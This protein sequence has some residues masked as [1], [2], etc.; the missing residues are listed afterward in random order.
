LNKRKQLIT[1]QPQGDRVFLQ[2]LSAVVESSHI[3]TWA[4]ILTGWKC[5]FDLLSVSHVKI[6]S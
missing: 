4:Q 6:E 2:D 3:R 1:D 5:L